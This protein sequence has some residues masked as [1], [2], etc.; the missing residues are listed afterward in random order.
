[1][2][3]S[4]DPATGRE[5]ASFPEADDASIDTALNR[6][7]SARQAWRDAGLGMRTALMRSVAGV[8]RKPFTL[9]QMIGEVRRVL[10]AT[11]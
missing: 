1:M 9:A 11:L 4:I 2:L 8:L 3:R 10:R 7:W 5:I 6:A